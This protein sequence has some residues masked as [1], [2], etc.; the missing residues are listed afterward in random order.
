MTHLLLTVRFL[1]DRY[2]GLLDR[3]GPSE[4]P[5]SPFRLFQAL[6]AG[7]ARRG[8]LDSRLGESLAW[9]QTLE[10]PAIVAPRARPGQVVTRF[11][12][13]ND[14]DKKPDRQSRLT[15]K[16][17]RPTIM[18]DSP[19]IHYVWPIDAGGVSQARL[20]CDAARYLT[21]LGWGIDMAYA[22]GRLIG[23]DEI[24]GLFGV[25]WH[26]RKGVMD[27]SGL[28]RVPIGDRET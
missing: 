13:N 7:V 6:V 8:E 3:Q 19:E 18:L 26:P 15:A 11:V 12:P 1:D 21:C 5:P 14:G 10:P 9:L 2:H 4:W 17:F 27:D 25:R 23:T 20:V 24:A 16:I 28:L 22:D